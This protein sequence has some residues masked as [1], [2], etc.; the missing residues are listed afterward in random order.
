[1]GRAERRRRGVRASRAD[2]QHELGL[3]NY[4]IE[5]LEDGTLTPKGMGASNG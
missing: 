1:M 4:M 3:V 5:R 2:V